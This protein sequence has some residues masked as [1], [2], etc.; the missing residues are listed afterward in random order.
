M[1][2]LEI[3]I[4]IYDHLKLNGWKSV[5]DLSS[6]EEAILILKKG[7]L[8]SVIFNHEIAKMFWGEEDVDEQGRNLDK[9]WNQYW[10]DSGMYIDKRDFEC[11]FG[12]DI[13]TQISWK[14]HLQK[15]VLEKEPLKYMEKFL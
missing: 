6:K 3:L 8:K 11:E 7:L 13:P 9:A 4:K 2:E 15:M 12:Y 14:Y 5:I 1:N 10:E